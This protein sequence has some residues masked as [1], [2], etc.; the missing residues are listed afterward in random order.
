MANTVTGTCRVWDEYIEETGELGDCSHLD[1]NP[2]DAIVLQS[3][4]IYWIHD[5]TPHES[6]ACPYNTPRQ[7]FRL[8][9]NNT[10]LWYSEHNTPNPLGVKPDCEVVK[11]NKFKK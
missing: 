5:R 1:L 6:L 3:N 2:E 9:T 7:F 11:G 10:S 4:S 8:V